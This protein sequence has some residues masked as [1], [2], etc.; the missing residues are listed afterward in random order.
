MERQLGQA[1]DGVKGLMRTHVSKV[2]SI[3]D[4]QLTLSYI[5]LRVVKRMQVY[6]GVGYFMS[7]TGPES[8]CETISIYIPYTPNRQFSNVARITREND[9]HL[10]SSNPGVFE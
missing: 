8:L 6:P 7:P 10:H 2:R 1:A 3:S 5:V 4:K 9:I